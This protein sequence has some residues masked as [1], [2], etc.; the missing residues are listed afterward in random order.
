MDAASKLT[1]VEGA[2]A[3]IIF[4]KSN[5]RIQLPRELD[6]NERRQFCDSITEQ[7]QPDLNEV[8]GVHPVMQQLV[9]GCMPE[10]SDFNLVFE[11]PLEGD[12][13]IVKKPDAS[14]YL[15][16]T[17]IHYGQTIS[18]LGLPIEGK[19]LGNLLRA[20]RQSLGY[21]IA[22]IRA[23]I[24]TADP[25][26]QKLFGYCAGCDGNKI[27]F[28]YAEIKDMK[29]HAWI[30]PEEGFEF[31]PRENLPPRY[32]SCKYV[33]VHVAT[34][35]M[36]AM[37]HNSQFGSCCVCIGRKRLAYA[38]CVPSL[39][40]HRS[41]WVWPSKTSPSGKTPSCSFYWE[42]GAFARP[43]LRACPAPKWCLS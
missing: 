11:I 30:T 4:L 42:K 41:S 9:S 14:L 24:Y 39:D 13:Y 3:K 38:S 21:L 37:L 43:S 12:S 19:L 2:T 20:I 26:V 31:W 1:G 34:V 23:Q 10:R 25:F 16:D 15:R 36:C 7:L 22:R 28:G 33:H 40:R 6:A 35:C 18:A 8:G 5:A 17:V 27:V 32:S 29:L